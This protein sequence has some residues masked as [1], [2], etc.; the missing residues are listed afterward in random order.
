ML[1]ET[2]WRNKWI[3]SDAI[4][5]DDMIVN[6]ENA[7]NELKEFKDSNIEADFSGAG[8]DYIYFRTNDIVT[9]DKFG[10]Y[11]VQQKDEEYDDE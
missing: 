3:T 7:I 4:S 11:E 8:D 10:L 2:I 5:I 1:Y 6:L 9:A